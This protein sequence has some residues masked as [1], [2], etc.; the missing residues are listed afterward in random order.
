MEYELSWSTKEF[1]QQL[2]HT[3]YCFS[4]SIFQLVAWNY[5]NDI[6]IP[7][8]KFPMD[9][10]SIAWHSTMSSSLYNLVLYS[11]WVN[12]SHIFWAPFQ[13]A[14]SSWIP[15][16]YGVCLCIGY[17]P[18]L[19][20]LKREASLRYSKTALAEQFNFCLILWLS[21]PECHI[22]KKG[23]ATRCYSMD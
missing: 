16:S 8:L 17:R 13:R 20:F 19:T 6:F 5:D 21:K 1:K 9:H 4:K 23:G 18:F 7:M 14:K 12:N 11:Y 3:G 22:F 2:S 15:Q 10:E